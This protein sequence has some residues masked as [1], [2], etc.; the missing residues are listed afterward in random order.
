MSC[1]VDTARA[2]RG[3]GRRFTVQR[4]KVAA[5]LRHASG[6]RTAE[7]IHALVRERDPG[8]DVPLSTVYRALSTLKELRLVSEV[9][10]A[11]RAAYEWVNSQEPHHHLLCV[12]CGAEFDLD[13]A[14]LERLARAI[15]RQ[16][17]FEPHLDH[18]AI[19]GRCAS[20]RTA[21]TDGA[22]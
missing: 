2:L 5:A 9:A 22:G 15:E 10:S 6:H 21:A 4:L 16:T 18:L 20:C 3:N 1:E 11:G 7:E 8:L 14:L 13:H 17:G 12:A 19:A